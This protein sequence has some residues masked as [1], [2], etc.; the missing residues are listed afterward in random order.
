[1]QVCGFFGPRNVWRTQQAVRDAIVARA[2]AEW[3]AWHNGAVPVA[4]SDTTRF[5]RL[6]GYSLREPEK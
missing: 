6:V 5:G 4:E 2:E 1:V 3:T